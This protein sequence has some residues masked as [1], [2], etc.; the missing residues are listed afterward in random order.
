MKTEETRKH[1]NETL[2]A[3][4]QF[5]DRHPELGGDKKVREAINRGEIPSVTVGARVYVNQTRWLRSQR[6]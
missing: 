4:G 6:K 2:M 3:P 1:F 5:S